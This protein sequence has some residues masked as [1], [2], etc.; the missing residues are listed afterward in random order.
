MRRHERPR[1]SNIRVEL[2]VKDDWSN[3]ST[4]EKGAH[5]FNQ[6]K[7]LGNYKKQP[8]MRCLCGHIMPIQFAYRCYMCGAFWCPK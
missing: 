3:L 5:I 4:D 7:S 2:P 1:Q 6:I 8:Q